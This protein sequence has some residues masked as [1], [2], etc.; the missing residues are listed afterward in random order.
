MN[1]KYISIT[2]ADDKVD[3]GELIRLSRAFPLV[4]WAILYYPSRTG[5]NRN[6]S[7]EWRREFLA[8]CDFANKA[9]HLCETAVPSFAEE[10]FEFAPELRQFGRIQLNFTRERLMQHRLVQLLSRVSE[11]KGTQFITQE[12]EKNP[13]VSGLFSP[14]RHHQI[15][16]D[17][18]AGHGVS[19][20]QWPGTIPGKFCG[21]AGGLAPDNVAAELERIERAAGTAPFWI[22]MESGVRTDNEFDLHKV[23]QVLETVYR[24]KSL[25]RS[26]D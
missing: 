14:N 2:G 23:E 26:V 25:P 24:Q 21:Y 9:A 8:R 11:E 3:I 22:D 12:N 20:A 4:E 13:G 16:F 19:P 10:G 7:A 18:S 5:A 17:A 15:L 1:L 6:P